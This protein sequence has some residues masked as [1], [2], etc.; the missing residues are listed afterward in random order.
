MNLDL[1]PKSDF[2][3]LDSNI[4]IYAVLQKSDQCIRL[5]RRC[6]QG[7]VVGVTAMPQF[8]E[9][10]HRLM[11]IEAHDND[12][13]AGGNP[14]KALSERPDRVQ[15]LTRYAEAVKGLLASG[16][17]YEP[18]QKE[19]FLAALTIQREYGL[20]TTD[21]LLMAVAERLRIQA[22]ASADKEF[23]RVRGIIL[24]SPDDMSD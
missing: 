7:D 21:A 6:S 22:V 20:M 5:L 10:M 4:F 23:A 17:R 16:I 8:A 9:V 14:V 11:M 24:Y 1:I 18:A 15:K 19:D 3:F 13:A 2:V 12:W